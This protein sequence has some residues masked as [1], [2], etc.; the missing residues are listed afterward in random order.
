M[1]EVILFLQNEKV[2]IIII[3]TPEEPEAGFLER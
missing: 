3:L 1:Q 2:V